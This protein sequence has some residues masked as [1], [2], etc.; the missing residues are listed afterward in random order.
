MCMPL[1]V[2]V[3]DPATGHTRSKTSSASS[4]SAQLMLRIR[5]VLVLLAV[6]GFVAMAVIL[7]FIG[8]G[9]LHGWDWALPGVGALAVSWLW[10]YKFISTPWS[11]RFVAPWWSVGTKVVA[12]AMLGGSLL[13]WAALYFL[14]L[15]VPFFPG[16]QTRE[17][18]SALAW[19]VLIIVILIV[20]TFLLMFPIIAPKRRA[21]LVWRFTQGRFMAKSMFVLAFG[22]IVSA[23]IALWDQLLLLLARIHWVRYYLP[24]PKPHTAR[25]PLNVL[26]NGNHDIFFLLV[27]Q[28]GD[29]VPALKVDDAIGFEQPLFYNWPAGWLVLAFKAVVGLALIGSVLAIVQAQQ[30]KPD[31]PAE[32]SLLPHPIQRILPRWWRARRPGPDISAP[33][34]ADRNTWPG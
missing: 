31:K 26:I 20:M 19:H 24:P 5:L 21:W 10:S 32:V 30:A 22:V 2:G 4:K 23:S 34:T 33:E 17:I 15:A 9:N 28:L 16:N 8:F 14:L 12:G 25:V 29:M 18:H 6:V 27:W 3:S 13:V 11:D 1:G 7:F